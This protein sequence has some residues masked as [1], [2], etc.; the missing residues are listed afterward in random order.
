MKGPGF[1]TS[2]NILAEG[3]KSAERSEATESPPQRSAGGL[4]H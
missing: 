4:R 3:M 1:H 2:I